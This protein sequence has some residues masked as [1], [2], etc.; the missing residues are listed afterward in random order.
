MK[1]AITFLVVFALGFGALQWLNNEP[2][3]TS[4][5]SEEA[6]EKTVVPT[7]DTL[8][9]ENTIDSFFN[10]LPDTFTY[11]KVGDYYDIQW[12]DLSR[13][14]FEERMNEDLKVM[15]P[16]PIFHPSVKRLDGKKIQ[17]KGYVIP[18]EET[19]DATIVILSA[20]PFSNCF[21]CGGAGAE[22]VIDVQLKNQRKRF[23]QDAMVTFRGK[24]RLNDSD[25]DYLNYILD[26]ADVME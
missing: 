23:K 20:F 2:K 12:K 26:D 19:G 10:S 13:V 24:L 22:T 1:Y 4:S 17:I 15:V 18:F 5:S 11:T 7:P 16:Y 6:P 3:I 25:L 21:F 9:T 14:R 8:I